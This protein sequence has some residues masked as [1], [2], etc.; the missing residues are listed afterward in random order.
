MKVGDYV[1]ILRSSTNDD[2]EVLH[3]IILQVDNKV[4]LWPASR[5]YLFKECTI[6][7]Y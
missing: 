1:E 7:W 2:V 4:G 5:V 3:G 6:S